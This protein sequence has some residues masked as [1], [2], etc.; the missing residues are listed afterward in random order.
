[1][2]RALSLR[3]DEI[4]LNRDGRRFLFIQIAGAVARRIVCHLEPGAQ[5]RRGERMG[6]IMF[7]SRVDVW[8]PPDVQPRVQAG[9]RVA[10]G[11]TV[12]AEIPQA[13]R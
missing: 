7:G 1:M 13:P 12:L 11:T 4:G 10:A 9:D 2:C 5:V 3:F 6:L 8:L